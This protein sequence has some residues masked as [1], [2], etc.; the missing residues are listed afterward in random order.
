M[1]E[2]TGR[3]GLKPRTRELARFQCAPTGFGLRLS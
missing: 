2:P 1:P 3:R